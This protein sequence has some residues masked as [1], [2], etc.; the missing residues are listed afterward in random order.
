MIEIIILIVFIVL[1]IFCFIVRIPLLKLIVALFSIILALMIDIGFFMFNLFI[2][3][4]ALINLI[5]TAI[6]LRE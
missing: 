2:I 5:D 1:N 4:L 3:L 6:K